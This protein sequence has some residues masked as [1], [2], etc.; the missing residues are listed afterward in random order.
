MMPRNT[1][2]T[3]VAMI[4]LVILL[5]SPVESSAVSPTE[6][7]KMRKIYSY[8]YQRNYQH[9][10]KINVTLYIL[11]DTKYLA[12]LF[13]VGPIWHM[14]SGKFGIVLKFTGQIT[15][16]KANFKNREGDAG[17]IPPGLQLKRGPQSDKGP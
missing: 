12:T 6:Y 5:E 1:P 17:S 9:D 2:V 15:L 11:T 7:L 16:D 13:R 10:N 4:I 14:G 8:F 3:V